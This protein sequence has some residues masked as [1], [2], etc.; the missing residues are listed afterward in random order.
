[1][2]NFGI[3]RAS[4]SVSDLSNWAPDAMALPAQ[5]S[6]KKIVWRTPLRYLSQPSQPF[7]PE[8]SL[9]NTSRVRARKRLGRLGRRLI[10]KHLGWDKVGTRL[11][12]QQQRLGQSL[13]PPIHPRPFS[14]VCPNRTLGF[15]PNPGPTSRLQKSRHSHFVPS[16]PLPL[17]FI[18]TSEDL[19]DRHLLAR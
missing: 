7:H 10:T 15:C 9:R 16:R 17:R 18:Q 4:P 8:L 5:K 11:G 14:R 3:S 19:A 12:Q 6:L 13:W 1:L 2:P